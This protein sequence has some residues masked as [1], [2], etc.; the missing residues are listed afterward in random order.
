MGHN[1]LQQT[2]NL[3][4]RRRPG[5]VLSSRTQ[6][7]RLFTDMRR[8]QRCSMVKGERVANLFSTGCLNTV[9][10]SHSPAR[11]PSVME[12]APASGFSLVRLEISSATG[13]MDEP[14]NPEVAT[15]SPSLPHAVSTAASQPTRNWRK[16]PRIRRG[17][18]SWSPSHHAI[19]E[20]A[21][22][23]GLS[24]ARPATSRI[25]EGLGMVPLTPRL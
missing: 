5:R 4:R 15:A 3:H 25:N 10:A 2:K 14:G 22:C 9:G 20:A 23:E 24:P 12:T 18:L 6:F 13:R 7:W 11:A 16:F 21:Y 8:L 19:Y 17:C 1:F